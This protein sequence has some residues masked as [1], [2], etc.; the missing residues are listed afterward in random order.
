[1]GLSLYSSTFVGFE[2]TIDLYGTN[3]DDDDCFANAFNGCGRIRSNMEIRN[4]NILNSVAATDDG[5]YLWESTTNLQSSLFVNNSRAIVFESTTGTPFAFTGI[6]FG[7]NTFDVRNE[8][9]G[10]ITIDVSDGDTPTYEDIGGGSS[11]T[12]NS[13]VNVI[14]HVEDSNQVDVANAR[15][16]ATRDFD[17]SVIINGV[18]TDGNG[19]ATGSTVS[20]AGGISIRVRKSSSG[21]TRYV[22]VQATAT[23]GGVS[24]NVNV[25]LSQDTIAT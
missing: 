21:S 15:V 12:V 8:S 6:E 23:V 17:E 4:C 16:Y 18:L 25:T 13:S 19:D 20:G 22:P 3:I 11:T 9:G 7:S 24:L 2:G 14:V 5:A 1:M 10:A